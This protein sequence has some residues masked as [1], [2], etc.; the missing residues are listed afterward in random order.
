[1]YSQKKAYIISL[2]FLLVLISASIFTLNFPRTMVNVAVAGGTGGVG[3]AIL[4]VIST[5]DKHQAFVLSRKASYTALW[6]MGRI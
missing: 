3:R 6:G 4:D 1:M 5:T 2:C